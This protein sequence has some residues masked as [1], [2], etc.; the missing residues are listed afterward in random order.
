MVDP[1]LREGMVEWVL[2]HTLRHHL[3]L[4]RVLCQQDGNWQAFVPPLARER[5]VSVLG[6]GSLGQACAQA[7]RQLNFN[8]SGWSRTPKA[9]SG[10]HCFHGEQG[11]R[12][13]LSTAEILILLLPLTPDTNNLMNEETLGWLPE[14][15]ILIN[16][17]RGAL[18]DD[19]ALL[20]ALNSGKLSQAT[21][22][23]F[24]EEPLPADHAFWSHSKITV[25]PHIASATRITGACQSIAENI[26]R[27]EAGLPLLHLANRKAGY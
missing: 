21:L 24:R 18:I 20:A 25:S 4:D 17:G 5:N 22:D 27:F 3:K 19:N 13:A 23:V 12:L 7:L 1:G 16:P 6:L 26:G 14:K 15:A 9:I 2:G 11:L 10:I 8:V